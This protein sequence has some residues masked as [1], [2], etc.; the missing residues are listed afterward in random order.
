MIQP[1]PF[2]RKKRLIEIL[3]PQPAVTSPPD[4]AAWV[5]EAAVVLTE[6]HQTLLTPVIAELKPTV[7]AFYRD[8]RHHAMPW[9][10]LLQDRLVA[11]DTRWQRFVETQIDPLFGNERTR[12]HA[13]LGM[14]TSPEERDVNRRVIFAAGNLGI[15]WAASYVFLPLAVVSFSFSAWISWKPFYSRAY[16][17]L[18]HERRLTYPVVIGVS[19]IV[20][21]LGGYFVPSSI[22][23]LAIITMQK[24]LQ[25]TE[26]HFRREF[27]GIFSTPPRTVWMLVEGAEIE[28]DFA[29]IK[30]GDTILLEGGQVVPVDGRVVAG[31]ATVDQHMLTGE[32]QPAEKEAGDHVLAATVVLAGKLYVQ[33]EKTGIE[34]NAAQIATILERAA[35]YRVSLMSRVNDFTDSMV[36]PLL[37]VGTLAWFTLGSWAGA[38]IMGMGVGAIARFGGPMAM[39]SYLNIASQQGILVK[40]AASLEIFKRVDTIVFD[41]TGTLTLEMPQLHAI[42]CFT[43]LSDATL[44]TYAA[45]AESK[46]EHPIAQAILAAAQA[47]DLPLPTIEDACYEIGYGI[48]VRLPVSALTSESPEMSADR[49]VRVGSQRFMALEGIALPAEVDALASSAYAQGHSLVFVAVDA[50]LAGVIELAPTIRPEARKAVAAL[51]RQGLGL[52]IISG[53]H[54]APTRHLAAQLGIEHSFAGVLPQDKAALVEQLKA[55]GRTV[56]FVGDGIN[57]ALAMHAA[58]TSVS[59][60]GATTIAT[61]TAQV[62]L[63][64]QDLSQIAFLR[65]MAHDFDGTLNMLFRL[66]VVP[67]AFVTSTTFLLQTG[68]Y[69]SVFIW[70]ISMLSGI[71][72]GLMPIYR[73]RGRG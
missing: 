41:K 5:D 13:A 32:G 31:A 33:V 36:F 7:T 73:Y 35:K 11:A 45:A 49:L 69:F 47:R 59:L 64:G 43:E 70:Q 65:S 12:Q 23:T 27:I 9:V 46:Q 37:G 24:L 38:A 57:D 19:Q 21:Y 30:V 67:I 34:T 68:I 42:H 28:V 54:E 48:K 58:Q 16:W 71:G 66:T 20:A 51:R 2:R 44:L 18:R 60:C 53:D 4:L 61:D 55:E 29:S 6:V 62:V 1:W 40:D 17:A 3:A 56:C 10:R 63:M 72:V 25:R 22:A 50:Q 39:L 52:Y 26:N 15:A 8:G 14:G